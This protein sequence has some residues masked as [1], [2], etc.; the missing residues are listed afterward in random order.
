MPLPPEQLCRQPRPS[1][2]SACRSSPRGPSQLAQA[3]PEAL[4]AKTSGALI[5]ISFAPVSKKK[6]RTSTCVMVLAVVLCSCAWGAAAWVAAPPRMPPWPAAGRR[7]SADAVPRKS[8]ALDTPHTSLHACLAHTHRC[9]VECACPALSPALTLSSL[10]RPPPRP[11]ACS[12]IP[13]LTV[14]GGVPAASPP[15]CSG[16]CLFI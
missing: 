7:E 10:Y 15:R 1:S 5:I 8:L 16:R 2:A 6:F 12:G 14:H 4:E 3:V 9:P 13:Q 11:A